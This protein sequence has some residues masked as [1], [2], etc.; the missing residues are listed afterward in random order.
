M[1][2]RKFY[3]YSHSTYVNDRNNS[4]TYEARTSFLVHAKRRMK[5]V[6][7]Q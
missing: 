1:Y 2:T 6:F 4:L 5:V 3:Y 7:G